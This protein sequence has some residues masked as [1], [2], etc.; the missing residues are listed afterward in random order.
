MGIQRSETDWAGQSVG[1]G[2]PPDGTP[3]GDSVLQ[4]IRGNVEASATRNIIDSMQGRLDALLQGSDLGDGRVN[5]FN[6]DQRLDTLLTELQ[7]GQ[8]F[9]KLNL[10]EQNVAIAVDGNQHTGKINLRDV[11]A[12]IEHLESILGDVRGYLLGIEGDTEAIK[13]AVDFILAELNKLMDTRGYE[14]R[15]NLHDLLEQLICIC[16]TNR[17]IMILQPNNEP[18]GQG[19]E[20]GESTA[21]PSDLCQRA[22]WLLD[23]LAEVGY[24]MFRSSG[25]TSSRVQDVYM[26]YLGVAIPGENANRIA[27]MGSSY[28]DSLPPLFQGGGAR[29]EAGR[30]GINMGVFIRDNADL[31]RCAIMEGGIAIYAHANWNITADG[32][33]AG[34]LALPSILKEMVWAGLFN[35]LFAEQIPLDNTVLSGYSNDC[36]DCAGIGDPTPGGDITT[37][38][39]AE[40][41]VGN[42]GP[43]KVINGFK[44]RPTR[45]TTHAEWNATRSDGNGYLAGN[46]GEVS[47]SN[48]I[49]ITTNMQDHTLQIVDNQ[50][51]YG[52]DDVVAQGGTVFWV[53]DPQSDADLETAATSNQI[54][55]GLG[56]VTATTTY[57][58]VVV[59]YP[60]TLVFPPNPLVRICAPEPS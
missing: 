41:E 50:A 4:G 6:L 17:Q 51:G 57:F 10:I 24:Q 30:G 49:F 21:A 14:D 29:A 38:Y 55:D 9:S 2:L 35:Q 53:N 11:K 22:H 32:L 37:R 16:T 54:T 45:I 5:L 47:W 27:L 59:K 18:Y 12:S 58:T 39:C 26:Q 8:I 23:V 33:G 13:P 3:P 15:T 56:T 28:L 25:I 44:Y 46:C 20:Q 60:D 34:A 1:A 52:Y 48:G 19:S 31:M 7:I 43:T 42:C 36:S 40:S